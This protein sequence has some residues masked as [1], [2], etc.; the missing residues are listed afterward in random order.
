[1]ATGGFDPNCIVPVT[2]NIA[3]GTTAVQ[4]KT[5]S[6]LAV[7]IAVSNPSTNPIY[8]GDSAVASTQFTYKIASGSTVLVGAE[9][10]IGGRQ[11]ESLDLARFYVR[12]TAAAQVATLTIYSKGGGNGPY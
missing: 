11:K 8:L 4:L 1:M 10:L 6:T 5:S 9:E 2:A 7:K 12:A 3:V